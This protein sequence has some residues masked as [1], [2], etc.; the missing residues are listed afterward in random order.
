MSR[1][2][3]VH[4]L[5]ANAVSFSSVVQ[6]GDSQE[7]H[8]SARALAVQRQLEYVDSREF[9][10]TFP[11]FTKTIP[12]PPIDAEPLCRH[13]LHDCPLIAVH[14]MRIIGISSTS[15]VHIGSTKTVEANSRVKHIRQLEGGKP[16]AS[17]RRSN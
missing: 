11:I 12:T 6:I 3:V 7:I 14:S 17:T 5:R 1:L 15:V 4:L 2:S 9:P 13:T 8:L 16:Y 10:L